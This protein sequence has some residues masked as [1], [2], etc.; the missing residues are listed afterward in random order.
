VEF[1]TSDA[2]KNEGVFSYE[3][4]SKLERGWSLIDVREDDE[5]TY[6]HHIQAK[7]IRM[8]EIPDNLDKFDKENYYVIACRSGHRSGKVSEYL[9]SL[10]FKSFN[11]IGGMKKLISDSDNIINSDG[12]IGTII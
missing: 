6:G 9:N 8:S 5:W 1:D 4:E 3:I 12:N 10:G 11:L 2:E 7:H